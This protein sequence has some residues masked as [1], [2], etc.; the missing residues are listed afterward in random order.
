MD[1][2]V[3]FT[4]VCLVTSTFIVQ[5]KLSNLL[6]PSYKYDLLL[7]N[8]SEQSVMVVS[9][10][11][12]LSLGLQKTIFIINKFVTFLPLIDKIGHIESAVWM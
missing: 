12:N 5:L 9:K 6:N 2:C 3:Y 1:T 7:F 11:I 8:Q 10:V 4:R